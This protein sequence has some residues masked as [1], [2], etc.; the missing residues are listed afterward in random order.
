MAM[1]NLTLSSDATASTVAVGDL[2]E[3]DGSW[4]KVTMQAGSPA[5]HVGLVFGQLGSEHGVVVPRAGHQLGQ[6]VVLVVLF[7]P[8]SRKGT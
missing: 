8:T 2:P 6:D 1:H 3:A 5:H 4:L 7:L